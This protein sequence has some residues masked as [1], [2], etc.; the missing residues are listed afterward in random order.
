MRKILLMIA[1]AAA[2]TSAQA[3]VYKCKEGGKTVFSDIPCLKD[4]EQVQ[5][6]PASGHW[7]A[8][9]AA[10][11]QRE[12]SDIKAKVR[13]IDAIRDGKVYVG[14]SRDDV[15]ESWGPPSKVNRSIYAGKA[16]EQWVYDR[17]RDS[18]YVYVENGEVTAIQ[19]H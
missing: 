3:Q 8:E 12:S 10:R 15:I 5:V 4:G 13:R 14:M 19:S 18:Q 9:N 16:S 17:G 2:S 7:N 1:V 11:S 6:A